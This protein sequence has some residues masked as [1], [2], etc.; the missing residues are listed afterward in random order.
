MNDRDLM[1]LLAKHK[2]AP[3]L[4]GDFRDEASQRVW[5]KIS[6]DLGFA[7][8]AVSRRTYVWQ[9]FVEY[10]SW[11]IAHVL[12]RPVMV[13]VSTFL[14][15]FGGW[16]VT[17]NAAFN[18]VPGDFLYPVKLATERVQL[19]LA[20]N[21]QRARLHAEFASR[22]LDEVLE[23]T[24]STRDGKDVRVRE[25]VENFKS[26]IASASA[27]LETIAPEAA[28]TIAIAVDRKVEEYEAALEQTQ[29]E[30][31]TESLPQVAEAVAA[32][33]ETNQQVAE[34][35]IASHEA[36][37]EPETATYLQT[38]FQNDLVDIQNR[39]T[40]AFGRMDAIEVAFEN[41]ELETESADVVELKD[42]RKT[43]KAM[44]EEMNEA[45]G[46]FAAGGF[47]RVLEIVS[48][49]K[50]TLAQS[51]GRLA[52][53]EIEITTAQQQEQGASGE[54]SETSVS[55]VLPETL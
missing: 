44:D 53:M 34:V 24:S 55:E 49:L 51:E 45:M 6:Y 32:V 3:E 11:R 28:A 14:I 20:N 54:V 2:D 37:Q 4:G 23:I 12:M 29:V 52:E 41:V 36:T 38:S 30:V 13:G 1:K 5:S 21:E 42:L 9:D 22:R 10:V 18:T 8:S 47:R 50:G 48:G 17:V 40:L 39:Q 15:V 43:L 46:L 7:S 26:E 35:I 33:E 31:A 27:E 25:A 19:S 16:V